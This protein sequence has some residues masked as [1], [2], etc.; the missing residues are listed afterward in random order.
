[1]MRLLDVLVGG[2]GTM[3]QLARALLGEHGG[4]GNS[5]AWVGVLENEAYTM[6]PVRVPFPSPSCSRPGR[7]SL[8][9]P[10]HLRPQTYHVLTQPLASAHPLVHAL[11]PQS[12]FIGLADA[13]H[14]IDPHGRLAL[15]ALPLSD[16]RHSSSSSPPSPS[17]PSRSTPARDVQTWLRWVV[18]A[19]SHPASTV[20]LPSD[21]ALL[22][23]ARA[24]LER[25]LLSAASSSSASSGKVDAA[26]LS[27]RVENEDAQAEKRAEE[28]ARVG[29]RAKALRTTWVRYRQA[30]IRGSASRSFPS[31]RRSSSRTTSADEESL[32]CH[33]GELDETMKHVKRCSAVKDLPEEYKDA[34]EW[35]LIFVAQALQ[36]VYLLYLGEEDRLGAES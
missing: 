29:K 25:F 16:P 10:R 13:L 27:R 6:E 23:R 2:G 30:L 7:A 4:E 31:L 1:M 5:N 32:R 15:P 20:R 19:L 26:A 11:V 12:A 9:P 22:D 33:A 28:W 14:S 3:D 18:L 34:E 17:S 21:D 36:C 24:A 35:A 8:T